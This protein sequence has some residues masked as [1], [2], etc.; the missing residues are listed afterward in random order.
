M[1]SCLLSIDDAN[2]IL[3]LNT[4][5]PSSLRF[6]SCGDLLQ[7]QTI[8]DANKANLPRIWLRKVTEEHGF[9]SWNVLHEGLMCYWD[10]SHCMYDRKNLSL[11][12]TI[13]VATVAPERWSGS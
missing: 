1:V 12:A 10:V 11:I 8:H 2:N 9:G 13:M 3:L 7:L 5:V 6:S 4:S